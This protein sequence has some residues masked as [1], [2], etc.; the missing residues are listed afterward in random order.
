MADSPT[1]IRLRG[2]ADGVTGVVFSADTIT[3][4]EVTP[5]FLGAGAR[6]MFPNS[7]ANITDIEV[8]GDVAILEHLSFAETDSYSAYFPNLRRLVLHHVKKLGEECLGWNENKLEVVDLGE[9]EVIDAWAIYYTVSLTRIIIPPTLRTVEE[10]AFLGSN[11]SQVVVQSLPAWCGIQFADETANPVCVAG[12]IGTLDGDTYVPTTTITGSMLDEVSTISPYAFYGNTALTSVAFPSSIRT[13]GHHSFYNCTGLTSLMLPEGLLAI[14]AYAFAGCTEL[15][16]IT[17]PNS[18]QSL[19]EYAF[20][21]SAWDY[22]ESGLA[23]FNGFLVGI[24]DDKTSIEIPNTVHGLANGVAANHTNLTSVTIPSTVTVIPD[25]CFSGCSNL[26]SVTIN[27]ALTSIGNSA[28]ANCTS[29]TKFAVPYTVRTIG[30]YAFSGCYKKDSTTQVETGLTSITFAASGQTSQLYSIG[31]HA[32][33]EC[34]LLASLSIPDS[35]ISMGGYCCANCR[36]LTTLDTGNGI[37]SIEE[38]AF[39]GCES[40]NSVVFGSSSSITAIGKYAFTGGDWG[41]YGNAPCFTALSFPSSLQSIGDSAFDNCQSLDTVEFQYGLQTIGSYSFAKCTSLQEIEIPDSVTEL[42]AAAFLKCT[43][44]MSVVLGDGVGSLGEYYSHGVFTECSALSNITFGTGLKYISGKTFADCNGIQTVKIKDL[45]AWIGINFG[46][47]AA[48]P[49]GVAHKFY[50]G[51]AETPVTDLTI[52]QD[53]E[54]V[55]PFAFA[56]ASE[57]L[58][59][60]DFGNGVKSIGAAAFAGCTNLATIT[61]GNS[62]NAIN[63]S[64]FS[65][66]TNLATI[67]FGNGIESIEEDAFG[68]CLNISTVNIADLEKWIAVTFATQA[69]NPINTAHTFYINGTEVTALAIPSGTTAISKWAFAGDTAL[70]S[71]SFVNGGITIAADAFTGCTRLQKVAVRSIPDWLSMT[72]A[73]QM[74]NPLYYAH[75]IS[76]DYVDITDLTIPASVTSISKYAFVNATCLTSLTFAG[77][78]LTIGERAFAGCSSITSVEFGAGNVTVGESAF[79]GCASLNAVRSNSLEEWLTVQFSDL[80]SNPN[81]TASNLLLGGEALTELTIGEDVAHIGNYA[82]LNC[83]ALK[84]ITISSESTTWGTWAFSGLSPYGTV[85]YPSLL[86]WLQLTFASA[87]DNPL[88]NKWHLSVGGS[89]IDSS[90]EIPYGVRKVNDFA[91]VN[92]AEISNVIIPDTVTDIGESAFSGG[93]SSFQLGNGIVNIGRRA[94]AGIVWGGTILPDSVVTIGEEAFMMSEVG[95]PD[96]YEGSFTVGAN[97]NEIQ[98]NAITVPYRYPLGR[99][100]FLIPKDVYFK[101]NCPE[102]LIGTPLGDTYDTTQRVHVP[103]NSTGWERLSAIYP[104]LGIVKDQPPIS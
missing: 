43:S 45:T 64:A 10:D 53:C 58:V 12:S 13:I 31:D 56:G 6:D 41:G 23:I 47:A 73:T 98:S 101:G 97:V 9:V 37:A 72:F 32:F 70:T 34:R 1:T 89:T 33:S 90:L 95:N 15:S 67:S 96:A 52:P 59:S 75:T 93:F 35:C 29:L 61:F 4:L 39:C 54:V 78:N 24:R 22:D 57:T 83:T 100:Y 17:L 85:D 86:G 84:R 74:S 49:I 79:N 20:P 7:Y 91:F 30:A 80:T 26:T 25:N 81:S 87:E 104:S 28:F 48:N 40:L 63:A 68:G 42:G 21:S 60:V 11:V 102:I 71:V 27:G 55:K 18:L 94:F 99:V 51:D 92:V 14:D 8:L 44:L 77:G 69:S 36:G 62:T 50:L 103:S 46:S 19:G 3:S 38:Y 2:M 88:K 5:R 76:A 82:F 66:C 65:N 16:N